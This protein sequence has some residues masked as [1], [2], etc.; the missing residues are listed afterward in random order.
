VNRQI[1][2]SYL[3]TVLISAP[4]LSPAGAAECMSA[5]WYGTEPGNRTTT[6]EHH[7]GKAMTAAM[8]TRMYLGRQY[9]VTYMATG[10]SVV[11]RINDVGPIARTGHGIDISEAAARRSACTTTALVASA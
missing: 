10:K 7:T 6:G 11:V 5:S 9:H 1:A 8:P 3:A 4:F 2:I